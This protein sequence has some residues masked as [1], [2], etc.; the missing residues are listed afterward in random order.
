M[1]YENLSAKQRKFVEEYVKDFNATQAAIRS[2][3]SEK[4]AEVQ[5]NRLLSNANIK[6]EIK[7]IG[8]LATKKTEVTIEYVI[9]NLKEIVRRGM[10]DD[11]KP[12]TVTVKALE[13]LGK[14]QGMWIERKEITVGHE[15]SILMLK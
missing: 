10:E 15:D 11:D 4:G 13:L 5:G 2:G 14:Y 12:S 6:A 8:Q 9:D 7:R 1:L 3:Y